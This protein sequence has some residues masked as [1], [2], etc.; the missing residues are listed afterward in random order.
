M[1]VLLIL[2]LLFFLTI[3]FGLVENYSEK[4]SYLRLPICG[5]QIIFLLTVF[6]AGVF[7]STFFENNRTTIIFIHMLLDLF[8]INRDV[9]LGNPIT[10][11]KYYLKI[12]PFALLFCPKFVSGEV[13]F[14]YA[15]IDPFV[16]LLSSVDTF[17]GKNP[18]TIIIITIRYCCS[19]FI[20]LW[21]HN[22][23]LFH[24]HYAVMLVSI[25]KEIYPSRTNKITK[26]QEKKLP[27]G[28]RKHKNKVLRP[29][30]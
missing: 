3:N 2:Y 11:D 12:M 15:I 5:I 16:A 7:V 22:H 24:L 27:T 10:W 13:Y 19:A 21:C 29:L 1:Y 30:N 4:L 18:V 20:S 6:Y 25:Y 9:R 23:I 26:N 14:F 17:I 28:E 8:R